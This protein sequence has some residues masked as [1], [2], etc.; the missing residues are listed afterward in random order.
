MTTAAFALIGLFAALLLLVLLWRRS[1]R[2]RRDHHLLRHRS[3]YTT[4]D[5]NKNPGPRDRI[6]D[7][8]RDDYRK[9]QRYR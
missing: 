5:P 7:E 8:L 9:N 6:P 2:H 3:F 1:A 4:W